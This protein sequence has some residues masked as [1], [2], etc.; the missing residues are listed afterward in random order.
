MQFDFSQASILVVGDVML[1]R[2]WIGETTRISPEA[3]VPIVHVGQTRDVPG[4]AANVSVNM[5]N[6][7]A[8]IHL[9]APVGTDDAGEKLEALLK[10]TGITTSFLRDEAFQTTVKL[11]IVTR[12]QQVVRADFEQ[13]P[14]KELLAPLTR[15]FEECLEHCTTVVFS[16]YAKGSLADIHTMVQLAVAKGKSVL[17]DP[18]GTNFAPYRMATVL[19]PNKSEFM[20]VAGHWSSQEEFESKALTLCDRLALKALLITRA[21]EGMSLFV[22]NKHIYIPAHAKDVFDVSGAGDTV[23]ATMAVAVSCGYSFEDAAKLANRAA[24]IVIGKFGTTP[25]TLDD[26]NHE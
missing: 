4:G 23:I 14:P 13:S 5:A 16:D 9:L 2:Y 22:A 7:G 21:E 15:M 25:I 24:S 12:G 1:D 17:I 8:K 18:K 19:S 10:T 6:L 3:P 26:L 11:R 20:Q